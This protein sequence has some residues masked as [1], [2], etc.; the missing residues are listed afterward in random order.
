MTEERLYRATYADKKLTPRKLLQL[1]GT[2]CGRNI[3]HPNIWVNAVMAKYKAKGALVKTGGKVEWKEYPN[4]IITD[5][6]F[7]NE[8]KA[9]KDRGGISIRVNRPKKIESTGYIIMDM[10][11]EDR[12]KDTVVK[13]T[14]HESE[15]ALDNA[16]FQYT[17]ANI[18]T[19]KELVE[20]VRQILKK[21]ELI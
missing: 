13:Y 8:L 1:M 10:A 15:T 4:W 11:S 21:E 18:G 5:M 2:E 6:R 12:T 17:I 14:E 20:M 16:K 19:L 7:P 3:L 9:V